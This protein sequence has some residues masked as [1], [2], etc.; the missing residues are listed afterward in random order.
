VNGIR[1]LNFRI[2]ILLYLS[3]ALDLQLLIIN[4]TKMTFEKK[5][6]AMLIGGV[7][8]LFLVYW[9]FFR[10]KAS[11]S[12]YGLPL[13]GDSGYDGIGEINSNN[14]VGAKANSLGTNLVSG[15]GSGYTG[16]DVSES[17][18]RI[19]KSGRVSVPNK[20]STDARFWVTTGASGIRY[21][22]WIGGDGMV[23]DKPLPCPLSTD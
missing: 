20:G 19:N 17:N 16:K 12:S 5:H 4:L 18:W 9:F 7:V 23:H 13:I 6:W 14:Y 22:N 2:S 1:S 3:F 8:V 11:E 21:C 15:F 10:K